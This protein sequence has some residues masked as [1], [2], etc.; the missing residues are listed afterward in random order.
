MH[1]E[2]RLTKLNEYV[3]LYL[4]QGKEIQEISQTNVG[5]IENHPWRS[6]YLRLCAVG[7]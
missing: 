5:S 4:F 7:G 3:V 2:G 6:E 1:E